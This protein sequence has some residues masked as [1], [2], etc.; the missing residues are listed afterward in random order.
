MVHTIQ[1][2]TLLTFCL[3]WIRESSAHY[4]SL[5]RNRIQMHSSSASSSSSSSSSSS[6]FS[7][8][9]TEDKTLYIVR[10]GTTEMNEVLGRQ[11]WGS[12]DFK[13]QLLWDTVLTTSGDKCGVAQAKRLNGRL[14][15]MIL[16]EEIQ[17]IVSSP[18]TRTLQ[19]A[20]IVFQGFPTETPRII[21]PLARERLYLSSDV[22]ECKSTLASRFP[23]WDFSAIPNDDPWWF[24]AS[25]TPYVE[26]RPSGEYGCPGEPTE[27]FRERMR[28]LHRWLAQRP[29][30]TIA[31]VTH[32]GVARGL[33]G[34]SL[35]NCELKTCTLSSLLQEPKIDH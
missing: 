18:L 2:R 7:S 25:D 28:A 33:T 26:W 20:E 11:P 29:E 34:E 14:K 1:R 12:K 22:G 21:C 16:P 9:Q 24:T 10:H 5:R 30:K 32:W 15:K 17:A 8:T 31:L 4:S 3:L 27:V 13:D 6:R 19:T 35:H 23:T